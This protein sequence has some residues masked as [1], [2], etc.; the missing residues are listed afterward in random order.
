MKY[1]IR[2]RT[3]LNATRAAAYI[4]IYGCM[5]RKREWCDIYVLSFWL[6]V[7][8]ACICMCADAHWL[9]LLCLYMS[10]WALAIGCVDWGECGGARAPSRL[11][12][13]V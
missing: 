11:S 12:L 7:Q 1:N 10:M 9:Q 5:M 4:C 6:F 13:V 8:G 3:D 2:I